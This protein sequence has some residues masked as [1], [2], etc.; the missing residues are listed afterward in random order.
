MIGVAGA[1]M[2]TL[3]LSALPIRRLF[4]AG[5]GAPRQPLATRANA[6]AALGLTALWALAYSDLLVA[7]L[8]FSG[9]EAGAYAA[10]A[11]ASRCSCSC[12]SRQRP[13]S[14]PRCGPQR[15]QPRA[16]PSPGRPRR[17][18]RRVDGAH[19]RRVG[20]RGAADRPAV[21][22]GVRG[23]AEWLG[24]LCLAMGSTVSPSSTST[25]S[26]LWGGNASPSFSPCWW[27]PRRWPTRSSTRNHPS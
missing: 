18:R 19:R 15:S 23:R 24:P 3:G 10:A 16:A 17:R 5:R 14:F 13:S 7:R 20:L 8:A 22:L 25:T 6:G 27:R 9:D 11:V 4:H 21:R 26:S 2:L 12:P 1:T